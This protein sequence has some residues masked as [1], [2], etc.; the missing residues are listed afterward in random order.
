MDLEEWL[1]AQRVN[2]GPHGLECVGAE[3]L[4]QLWGAA[5]AAER[6]ACA[7]CV[8][9]NWCDPMLTGPDNV[10]NGTV[11]ETAV[12]AVLRAVWERIIKRSTA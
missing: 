5:T 3:R 9:M 12:E 6:E 1:E 8:P 2:G 7:A 10:L 4:R 11:R